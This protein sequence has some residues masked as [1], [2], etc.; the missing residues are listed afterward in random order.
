M[1]SEA[2][3]L[4]DVVETVRIVIQRAAAVDTAQTET[5]GQSERAE[6][7][8]TG[9]VV[10][11]P[12]QQVPAIGSCWA[13]ERGELVTVTGVRVT[14]EYADG[15]WGHDEVAEFLHEHRE[16]ATP[17]APEAPPEHSEAAGATPGRPASPTQP[18]GPQTP[19][20]EGAE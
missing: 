13:D 10:D 1:H 4:D 19:S 2:D 12:A 3:L 7:A 6:A 20:G 9:G 17:D 15:R 8:K 18:E 5:A 14:Y 16:D 11:T